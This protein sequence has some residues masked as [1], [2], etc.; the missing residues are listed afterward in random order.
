M[1]K[2]IKSLLNRYLSSKKIE[3]YRYIDKNHIW[4]PF[5]QAK[6]YENINMSIIVK[7]KKLKVYDIE[8]NFY[9]DAISSWWTSSI[10]H[11]NKNIIKSITKQLKKLD[12]IIF[13]GFTHISAIELIE[14]LKKLL[15]SSISRF[16]FSDNGSTSVEVALKIAFQY[17]YNKGEKK[18][19]FIYLKDSYHGDTIGSMSVG[20]IPLYQEIFKPLLFKGLEV[21]SP[22]CANC[23][24]RKNEFTFDADNICN[25]ECFE[26]MYDAI[27]KNKGRIAAVI[28]E[29]LLQGAAGMKVYPALYLKKL[30]ELLNTYNILLIFD[31]VATGFGRT[32]QMFAFKKAGVEPDIICLSKALGSGVLPLGLTGVREEI[33]KSFYGDYFSYKTFFHGHSYTAYPA[34]CAVAKS[35]IDYIVKN[36]L[37]YSNKKSFEHFH[38]R[39]KNFSK[40]DFVNDIRFIGSIGA[41]DI[42]KSRKNN[43]NYDLSE[44]IGFKIHLE[45]LKNNIILRPLGNTV[46]W[47]LPINFTIKDIDR[48]LD[49]SEYTIR[50]VLNV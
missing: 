8:G 18:D 1:L 46:Y 24:H 29:P 17:W 45:G 41:I 4:H 21:A 19:L 7:G 2:K 12:H 39:L 38:K 34:A 48:I 36:N 16:F 6:D 5:T 9:Y 13:A 37:P 10:G 23:K 3:Y 26:H 49:I 15:D 40:F 30:R 44:R 25:I 32:G 43:I 33:Y 22:D 28:V 31:E 14:K 11:C 50:K 27:E 47:F 20:G 42:V 35:H